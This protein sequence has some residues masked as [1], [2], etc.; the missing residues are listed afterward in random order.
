MAGN[1]G[2]KPGS[3]TGPDPV[4]LHSRNSV[5]KNF[6]D[7]VFKTAAVWVLVMLVAVAV[8]SIQIMF[9]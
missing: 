7:F 5:F 3:L 4:F 9:F 2:G 1:G 8:K 6:D